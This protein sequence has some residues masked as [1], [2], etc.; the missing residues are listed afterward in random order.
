MNLCIYIYGHRQNFGNEKKVRH[1]SVK[2]CLASGRI[3]PYFF[4][5]IKMHTSRIGNNLYNEPFW[6]GRD[7]LQVNF[8]IFFFHVRVLLG[9]GPFP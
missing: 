7:A 3:F 5:L 8:H 1:G 9:T 4:L 2:I 6:K